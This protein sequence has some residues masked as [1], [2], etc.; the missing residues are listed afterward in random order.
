MSVIAVLRNEKGEENQN[1]EKE[2]I[3]P[4]TGSRAVSKL[5]RHELDF[6][7]NHHTSH[8]VLQL[9]CHLVLEGYAQGV[10]GR[11]FVWRGEVQ[12]ARLASPGKPVA[13]THKLDFEIL[14]LQPVVPENEVVELVGDHLP[15]DW[16][17]LQLRACVD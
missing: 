17:L 8:V 7:P 11:P 15:R 14:E 4:Q 16:C 5:G 13:S 6:H 3:L 1:E 2:K 12:F 10:G 9:A